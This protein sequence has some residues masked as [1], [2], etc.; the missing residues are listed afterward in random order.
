MWIRQRHCK[1]L[2][3]AGFTLIE[4]LTAIF[5][6]SIVVSLVLGS[7]DGIF[8]TA[9]QINAST[10][11]YEMGSSALIRIVSDLTALHVMRYPRYEPPDIDDAPEMYRFVGEERLVGGKSFSWIR[12]TSLAHL[13]LNQVSREGI[14]QMVYYV[15]EDEASGYI[16]K[17]SDN[18]YPY[19]EFEESDDDPV[20]CEQLQ[21]FKLIFFD[22]AGRELESWDSE[23]DDTEYGTPRAVGIRL[24]VGET[25]A[26]FLFR[27]QVMLPVY[28]YQPVK[29]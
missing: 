17:R 4:I 26:P 18:L 10:D 13:P 20:V 27:T 22:E 25:D 2:P 9:D 16:L 14:A 6:L 3:T 19:P 21:E 8:S 1:R 11:Y 28:R 7:F 24:S 15:Q 23:D 12:F 5:I 29:R